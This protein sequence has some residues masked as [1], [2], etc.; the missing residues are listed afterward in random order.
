MNPQFRRIGESTG[1]PTCEPGSETAGPPLSS[2]RFVT[3]TLVFC[4]LAAWPALS[5]VD[6]RQWSWFDSPAFRYRLAQSDRS[7]IR[8][9]TRYFLIGK[10]NMKKLIGT[11]LIACAG[12]GLAFA[13]TPSPT[14]ASTAK[15]PSVSQAIKQLEQDWT[16]AIKAGDADKLGQI[17][18]DDWIG[19]TYDG[20]KETKQ[21]LLAG[22]KSGKNKAE[23]AE[24]GP[25]DVK[26][27][28]NVAVVQGSDTEKSITNGKDSS[29]KYV[30]MDV[31]AKRDGKWVAVRSEST[32]VK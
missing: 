20:R 25:M 24:N 21:S 9:E 30:W 6:G 23:S 10:S 5:S 22:V 18:A 11:L 17:V 29:G 15:A 26:V 32:M 2:R 12:V 13:D 31:F 7:Q 27:L 8:I 3:H 19:L 14:A 28:G 1:E 4:C 16:D